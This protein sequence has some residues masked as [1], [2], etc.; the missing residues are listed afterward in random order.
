MI[1]IQAFRERKSA[2]FREREGGNVCMCR[3][4]E[5][6]KCVVSYTMVFYFFQFI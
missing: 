4:S 6:R 2:N 1:Q 5:R 3:E